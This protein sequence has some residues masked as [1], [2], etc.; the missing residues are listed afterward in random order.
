[1]TEMFLPPKK[2]VVFLALVTTCVLTGS[3]EGQQSDFERRMA[4]MQQA[5]SRVQTEPVRVAENYGVDYQ[6]PPSPEPTRVASNSSATQRSRVLL[7]QTQTSRN[8]TAQAGSRRGNQVSQVTYRQNQAPVARTSRAA[9]PNTRILP[10]NYVPQHLRTAQAPMETVISGAPMV[11]DAP[12]MTNSVVTGGQVMPGGTIV[13]GTGC[14][15]SGCSSCVGESYFEDDCCGRGGCPSGPCWMDGLATAFVNGEYFLGVNAFQSPLFSTPGGAAGALS[16][17]A[18]FGFYEGFNFGL[19]L[20]P[21]SC[22]AFSGQIGLR[23]TQTNFDGNQF[24]SE[25]RD[26]LFLTAGLFRRVDYGLQYG[27]AWDFLYEDWFV[28]ADISQVRA[29]VSWMFAGGTSFGFRY[30]AGIDDAVVS[31]SFAGNAFTNL[32][33]TAEDTYRFYLDTLTATN[34]AANVFVGWTENDQTFFGADADVPVGEIVALQAGFNYYLN[35]DGLPAGSTGL[36]GN[37]QDAYNI[38]VGLGF[39]PGGRRSMRSY[40]RPMFGVADNGSMLISRN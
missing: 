30:S 22:G 29:D 11:T 37:A 35:G 20:C 18:S 12:V 23:A 7:G 21:L 8:S 4:A 15:E 31:G 6:A 28:E 32:T 36:G 34:G 10:R 16:D 14:C 19:P 3:T 2:A 25:G 27:V 26:Q 9:R 40:D 38:Y 5:R 39:R 17:D 33:V 13:D 1:M 24:T